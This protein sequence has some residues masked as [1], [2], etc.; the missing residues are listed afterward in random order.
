[1]IHSGK[2]EIDGTTNRDDGS[3][4]HRVVDDSSGKGRR[5]IVMDDQNVILSG[6]TL[7]LIA[8]KR[9]SSTE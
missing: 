4:G 6:E 7:R 9:C 8:F 3:G 2:R 5:S 1:M